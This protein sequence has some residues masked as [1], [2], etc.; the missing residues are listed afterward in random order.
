M[1]DAIL[2]DAA[3]THILRRAICPD[4]FFAFTPHAEDPDPNDHRGLPRSPSIWESSGIV[5]PYDTPPPPAPT[6]APVPPSTLARLRGRSYVRWPAPAPRTALLLVS[7]R[8]RRV[9]TPLLYASVRLRTPADVALLAAVLA[10]HPSMGALVRNLRVDG[11]ACENLREAAQYMRSVC[12][13]HVDLRVGTP[14]GLRG[15]G[16]ALEFLEPTALYMEDAPR[17]DRIG[18]YSRK[19]SQLLAVTVGQR[20]TSLVRYAALN[21]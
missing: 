21:I 15:L 4:A 16:D 10:T 19:A 17:R 12:A 8:W 1:T 13:L 18:T 2:S 14:A 5:R 20:W 3:L 11:P 9:G 6:V 7:K